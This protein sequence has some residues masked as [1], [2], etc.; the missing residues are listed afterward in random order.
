VPQ[1]FAKICKIVCE[2]GCLQKLITNRQ[3]EP[4]TQSA[5]AP[6]LTADYQLSQQYKAARWVCMETSLCVTVDKE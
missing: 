6:R 1:I 4:S 2:I 5:A 3:T